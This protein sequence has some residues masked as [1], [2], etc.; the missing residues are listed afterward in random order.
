MANISTVSADDPT[1]FEFERDIL[2]IINDLEQNHIAQAQQHLYTQRYHPGTREEYISTGYSNND[3][4]YYTCCGRYSHH[5]QEMWDYGC[6][7]KCTMNQWHQS[8]KQVTDLQEQLTYYKQQLYCRRCN[9]TQHLTSQCLA[10]YCQQCH[11]LQSTVYSHNAD[12]YCYTHT[13][14]YSSDDS[15]NGNSNLPPCYNS[16]CTICGA[17]GHSNKFCHQLPCAWC[18]NLNVRIITFIFVH[19]I[20]P[21][22]YCH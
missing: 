7:M 14:S 11:L 8:L 13:S 6:V 22:S 12:V 17:K 5:N 2:L 20:F 1:L 15:S 3:H 10:K 16:T 4:D 19:N 18:G 9:S 21:A